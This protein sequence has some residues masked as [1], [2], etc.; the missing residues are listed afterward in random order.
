MLESDLPE[1]WDWRDVATVDFTGPLL[2]QGG[3]GSC[4]MISFISG[5]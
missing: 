4:Y 2:D 5:L 3:C 1:N